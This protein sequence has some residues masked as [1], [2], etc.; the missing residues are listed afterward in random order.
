MCYD[1]RSP[2]NKTYPICQTPQDPKNCQAL[3]V[4][5]TNSNPCPPGSM[6]K[7]LGNDGRSYCVKDVSSPGRDGFT[8]SD[9]NNIDV[10][11]GKVPASIK[12]A[13]T[14]LDKGKGVE[15]I[16]GLGQDTIGNKYLFL[17]LQL[18]KVSYLYPVILTRWGRIAA[19]GG[20]GSSFTNL[21]SSWQWNTNYIPNGGQP[22][23]Q[24]VFMS[25]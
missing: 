17:L 22:P 3:D 12:F 1:N 10:F 7:I 18:S 9:L 25:T 5:W 13:I 4:D 14:P 20:G 15:A 16:F 19:W 24:V 11:K 21:G 6:P 8:N 23:S 2:D